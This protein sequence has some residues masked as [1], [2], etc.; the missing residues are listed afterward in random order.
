MKN[1]KKVLALG[2]ALVMILGMFTIASAAETE[3]KTATEFTDWA[4]VE[5]KD[6]VA[7]CVDLGIING[8]PDGSFGPDQTI[9]RASWAKLVYFT[10]TGD[11]NADAY[12]GTNTGMNDIKGSW[13]ESYINYL[14]ANKYVSGDGLGN[15][16]PTGTI[17][18]AAGLKTMLTVLGYDADDRGYQ[19]DAAWMGNI[20]TDAKRNGLMDDVDRSQTAAVNLTRDN[21]AQ[22][23]YNALQANIVE[24]VPQWDG[25]NKYITTY[26]KGATLGYDVFKA[27]PVT[28]TVSTDNAGKITITPNGTAGDDYPAGLSATSLA[29]VKVSST[30]VGEQV[31]VWVK[32][33]KA[34]FGSQ[35]G[36]LLNPGNFDEV[37]SAAA[38][39]SATAAAKTFTDG[40]T[41]AD[42]TT[43]N[44]TS[45][46]TKAHYVGEAATG[47]KIYEDGKESNTTTTARKGDVVDVFTTDGKVS[48]IK[49]TTWNMYQV[50]DA[51]ETRTSG[52]DLQV[53]VPGVFTGWKNA[54]KV[55]GWQGLAKDD[56]VLVNVGKDENKITTIEKADKATGKVTLR[57]GDK[58]TIAGK[59]YEATGITNNAEDLTTPSAK[60]ENWDTWDVKANKDNEYDFYLDKNGSVAAYKQISGETATEVAYVV[61]TAWVGGNGSISASK[62][63]EANLLFTDGTTEIVKVSKVGGDKVVAA[64]A[65]VEDGEV[66][67]TDMAGHFID[68]SVDK[69]GKYEIK[70]KDLVESLTAGAV[71]QETG[72]HAGLVG[73]SKTTFLVKKG[74][75]YFTYTGFKNVPKMTATKVVAVAKDG[76]ATY[77]YFETKKFEGDG[78]KGL[79]YI[80]NDD[81]DQ[82][83]SGNDVYN[84]VTAEGAEE[85]M[86]LTKATDLSK[87]EAGKFYIIDAIDGDGVATVKAVPTTS[88]DTYKVGI[89]TMTA[90]N[91]TVKL[92]NASFAYDNET[93]AVIIDLNTKD[94]YASA[95]ALSLNGY[96][97]DTDGYDYA[98][99][100]VVDGNNVDY[101]YVVRGEKAIV[102][103]TP[104][105]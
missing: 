7:L 80:R 13:A 60:T 18:V 45:D 12:L 70:D 25:G 101:V 91:G 28:A 76:I 69:D 3:K 5:H 42:I 55:E 78:S 2:L 35:T 103:D 15:Y 31:T 94:E 87:I 85:K 52:D 53:K 77:V 93:V 71:K 79:I 47:M 20:M 56:V 92:D 19:N 4:D 22:I 97:E 72:F 6:A 84:V 26:N 32:A 64:D 82:D 62:Y 63:M 81:V 99:T 49:V 46:A 33:S 11:D 104:Q 105:G 14:V 8:L 34:S 73:D 48:T 83:T 23:V 9:D 86:A 98:I 41:L 100:L 43:E 61:E 24:G 57:S 36:E 38:A 54:D 40:V 51:I 95:G 10:A 30:L 37:I 17:T 39:K 67:Y 58:L 44:K 65:D 1:L 89:T 50:T 75:D 88:D 90:G 66:A 16:M 21:A 68:Y 27:L 29:D 59:A 102:E 74:D 96:K